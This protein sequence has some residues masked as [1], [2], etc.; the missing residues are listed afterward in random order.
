MEFPGL[1]DKEKVIKIR[2]P[3]STGF[4]YLSILLLVFSFV[5]V[6]LAWFNAYKDGRIPDAWGLMKEITDYGAIITL[7]GDLSGWFSF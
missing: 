2:K 7:E 1:L 5:A 6:G 3:I 4:L